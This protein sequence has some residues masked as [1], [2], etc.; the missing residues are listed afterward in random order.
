MI[1]TSLHHI[2][3]LI[4]PIS[5]MRRYLL[6]SLFL[7]CLLISLT[8]AQSTGLYV[9]FEGGPAFPT[10]TYGSSEGDEAGYAQVGINGT[11]GV[12]F[13][14]TRNLALGAK[15]A[16][17]QNPSD[18]G[19]GLLE[20]SPWVT[21]YYMA[22]L[23]GNLP[24]GEN[25]SLEGNVMAGYGRTQFP[26]GTFELGDITIYNDGS[27]GGGLAL[28]AGLGLRYWLGDY[29]SFKL[30]AT[31]LGSN[32]NLEDSGDEIPQNIRLATAN[33]GI[34]ITMN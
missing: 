9:S 23:T 14:L 6:A 17:T 34:M 15:L 21:N 1:F 5:H 13:R 11:A 12:G 27:T 32:P 19:S 16:F 18:D 22:D 28:G 10:G 24:L 3:S 29:V 31:Y 33:F 4:D 2:F 7:P 30:G 26:D 8:Q 20:D 25:F